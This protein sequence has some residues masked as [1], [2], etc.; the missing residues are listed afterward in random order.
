[1]SVVTATMVRA[2]AAGCALLAVPV[3]YLGASTVLRRVDGTARRSQRSDVPRG[4]RPATRFVILVPAH[5]E[6]ASIATMVR[7]AIGQDYP[8]SKFAVHV[9]ADNCTDSTAAV[10]AAAGAIVHERSEVANPGKGPALNWLVGRLIDRNEPFDAA[11]FV[12]ADTTLGDRFLLALDE[13]FRH[14]A[15]AVQG[16]YLVR[17]AFQSASTALRFCSLSSR[18]HARP[19][20]RTAVGGSCGLFGNGMAFTRDIVAERR[21]TSHLVEDMEFQLQ[22]LLAGVLVEY[23]PRARLEAEMPTTLSG[24]VTQH[25]RWELGRLDIVGRFAPQLARIAMT[26]RSPDGAKRISRVAAV[27][28]LLDMCVPPMSLLA[29]ATVAMAASGATLAVIGPDHGRKGAYVGAGLFAVVCVHVVDSMRSVGAPSE[30]YRA[31]LHAPRLAAWKVGVLVGSRAGSKSA[32]IR[33]Q[34]NAESPA[35]VTVHA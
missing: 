18:H 34:R 31:L 35:P 26:G 14:G 4:A 23:E 13:R 6:A 8:S 12:D 7:S 5:D 29:S 25:R 11:V 1:M 27:D 9:V 33:T 16:Q 30:A 28:G 10:A 17:D 32:W 15:V 20:A 2:T 22:L 3:A 24:S 19:L 21:W